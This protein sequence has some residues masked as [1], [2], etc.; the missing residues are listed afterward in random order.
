M[1]ENIKTT[2]LSN[3]LVRHTDGENY[4]VIETCNRTSEMLVLRLTKNG[5]KVDIWQRQAYHY[6]NGVF[7]PID[8]KTSR[9]DGRYFSNGSV[10]NWI[11]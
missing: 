6:F 2:F 10:H 9:T 1:K 4:L 3:S 11:E 8:L 5:E 7:T